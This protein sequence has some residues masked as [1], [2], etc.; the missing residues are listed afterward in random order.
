MKKQLVVMMGIWMCVAI[1]AL[2]TIAIKPTLATSAPAV[3]GDWDGA[4]S[5]GGGS[6]P[7]VIHVTQDKDGKLAA[8]LDSPSQGATGISISPI[9]FKAPDMHFEIEKFG[10]SYDGTMNTDHSEIAG[11]WKQGGQSLPLSFKR[12]S[13]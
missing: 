3:V 9:T 12:V 2:G 10:A 8:T 5:A 13:K 11:N 6:L 4:L 7:V 1:L